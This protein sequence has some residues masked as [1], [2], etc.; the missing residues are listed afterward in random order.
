[1]EKRFT[2]KQREILDITIKF[3]SKH[4]IKSFTLRNIAAEVGIRQPTLY[5]HFKSK[6]DILRGVFEIYKSE[7]STYHQ[8]LADVKATKLTK[9]KMYFKKMCEFIQYRPD[10][11][12]LV[13]FDIYQYKDIFK[14]DLNFLIQDMAKITDNADEDPDSRNDVDYQ[15]LVS[16]L[17]G[18]LYFYLKNK[19][20]SDDYDVLSN[21]D[22]CW[23]NVEKLLRK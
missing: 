17:H 9:I 15:W 4:G 23:E 14:E 11:M 21:A 13:M 1:M 2:K 16:M 18:I 19:L 20:T 10:Y 8:C 6:E 3:V 22:N 12:N 5:G 7:V